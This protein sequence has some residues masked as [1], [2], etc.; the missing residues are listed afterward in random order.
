M[1]KIVI[2]GAGIAGHRA[3]SQPPHTLNFDTDIPWFEIT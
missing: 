2:L 3:A 1:A